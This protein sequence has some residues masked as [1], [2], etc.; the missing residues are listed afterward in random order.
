MTPNRRTFLGSVGGSLVAAAL[1]PGSPALA[2]DGPANPALAGGPGGPKLGLVTYNVAK[3]WDVPTIIKNC[4][5]TGF[6]AVEL[7]TTHKHGVEPALAAAERAEVRK[8]FAD[9]NVRL[10]SLGSTCEFH[11]PDAKT[12]R[13]NIDETKRFIE[14]A[15]DLGCLG[16]KVRPNGIPAGVPEEKTIGQIGAAL[17]ECGES[18]A[19]ASVEIWVEV[20]GRDSAHP[21]R[22]AGMMKAA[23]HPS[24]A[25]CWNS[26]A[27]DLMGGTSV[28]PAFDLLKP[29]LRNC[30]INELANPKYP[31]R[32]LFTLLR[33]S[34][35]R[36]Y[37]LC[38]VQE[39]TDPIRFMRYYAALWREMM[40][41]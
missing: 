4:E 27:D 22:I 13:K 16:V 5:A 32:E 17:R 23:A 24:V 40:G 15:H 25:V 10:L 9:S 37:T 19:P 41:A 36:R 26:N 6:E 31:W 1:P 33:E 8:R 35:Y 2:A 34:G 30:H 12:V 21:P 3:D 28:K 39:S 38:E 14:L 29:W 20:H 7:R 18:A 11:A